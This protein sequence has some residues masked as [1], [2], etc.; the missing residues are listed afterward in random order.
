MLT[1]KRD[2]PLP[3]Q[4]TPSSDTL[5]T[6]FIDILQRPEQLGST[7]EIV[8][9]LLPQ[10]K[11]ARVL[12][13]VFMY[14]NT[15]SNLL[16]VQYA[17]SETYRE[18][19]VQLGISVATILKFF[20]L[21]RIHENDFAEMISQ[22]A[23]HPA[24]V[25]KE[26]AE[27]IRKSLATLLNNTLVP[28]HIERT[29]APNG[30]QNGWKV[31]RNFAQ[32]DVGSMIAMP[33]L[34]GKTAFARVDFAK[35]H[36]DLHLSGVGPEAL[37]E[38]FSVQPLFGTGNY[39]IQLKK[40]L[41]QTVVTTAGQQIEF[42]DEAEG[43]Q[44]FVTVASIGTGD[45]PFVLLEMPTFISIQN[46]VTRQK[47]N[48]PTN[49]PLPANISVHQKGNRATFGR[50][51]YQFPLGGRLSDFNKQVLPAETAESLTQKI[52]DQL[53]LDTFLAGIF[54][55][56]IQA[57]II[58]SMLRR[59]LFGTVLKMSSL[60][61]RLTMLLPLH[62]SVL[63]LRQ[64]MDQ[65]E[66]Q[67]LIHTE[68]VF[69]QLI[70]Q[71]H[72]KIDQVIK[73]LILPK[74]STPFLKE[75]VN[76]H[77]LDYDTYEIGKPAQFVEQQADTITQKIF[78]DLLS[79]SSISPQDEASSVTPVKSLKQQITEQ[80]ALDLDT[81]YQK[82]EGSRLPIAPATGTSQPSQQKEVTAPEM[83]LAARLER[84]RKLVYQLT[85]SPK[86]ITFFS[87]DANQRADLLDFFQRDGELDVQRLMLTTVNEMEYWLWSV[88]VRQLKQL[89]GIHSQL[90]S[91]SGQV[92]LE[93][94]EAWYSRQKT[95][96]VALQNA[97][98]KAK[99]L[100]DIEAQ[101][102]DAI[103]GLYMGYTW[104]EAVALGLIWLDARS[105]GNAK[106]FFRALFFNRMPTY[107]F[108]QITLARELSQTFNQL[109]KS[110]ISKRPVF[111]RSSVS[112]FTAGVGDY[113]L[114][115]ANHVLM[116]SIRVE[117]EQHVYY[118]YDPHIGEVHL[119]GVY[120]TKTAEA[121]K[122][123]LNDYLEEENDQAN[124]QTRAQRYGVEKING[125]YAFEIYQIN[126]LQAR[127]AWPVLNKLRT[128][129][130][131]FSDNL[132][133][134]AVS[135]PTHDVD[136]AAELLDQMKI[137]IE[138]NAISAAS[139][140]D[141][142]LTSG[143]HFD[144]ERLNYYLTHSSNS[145][146]TGQ[147]SAP[148]QPSVPGQATSGQKTAPQQNRTLGV[149]H[150]APTGNSVLVDRSASSRVAI[151]VGRLNTQAP[152]N[153]YRHINRFSHYGGSTMQG[154]GYARGIY[155]LTKYFEI[156]EN[157]ELS[158]PKRQEALFR[159]EMSAASLLSNLAI[160]GTQYGLNKLG[161]KLI[162]G[163]H[164]SKT[165]GSTAISSASKPSS[166][167]VGQ[168]IVRFGGPILSVIGSGF[169][170]YN[171]QESFSALSH[172]TG[173]K[174]RQDLIVS[175]SLSVIGA[176]VGIGTAIACALGGT[177]ATVAG[178][179]AL[180]AGL[181]LIISSQIYSSIRQIEELKKHVNLTFMQTL[182]SG[183][184][185]FWHRP[186]DVTIS[187]EA[188]Y[189]Q[190]LDQVR[191]QYNDQQE[192]YAMHFLNHGRNVS[193]LYY[194]RGQVT[195]QAH[196]YKRL[197]GQPA[198]H[199]TTRHV[200]PT[201]YY[202]DNQVIKDNIRPEESETV[203]AQYRRRRY[204]NQKEFINTYLQDSNYQFYTP[205]DLQSIDDTID[206]NAGS[207]NAV[208]AQFTGR[209]QQ[210]VA[211]LVVDKGESSLVLSSALNLESDDYHAL[212]GDFNGDGRLDIGYFAPQGFYLLTAG[213]NGAYRQAQLI[214]NM[215][216]RARD[217]AHPRPLVGDINSD[218][219][220]DI[221]IFSSNSSV[222]ATTTLNIMLAQE[223]GSFSSFRQTLPQDI[224]NDLTNPG[225]VCGDIDG[226]GHADL[227]SF[228]GG[229]IWIY[230][231]T[232]SGKFSIYNT[233][234][235]PKPLTPISTDIFSLTNLTPFNT[236]F[237]RSQ[238]HLYQRIHAQTVNSDPIPVIVPAIPLAFFSGHYV[239]QGVADINGDGCD[240]IVSFTEEGKIH[241]LLGSSNRQKKFTALNTQ[242]CERL[243]DMFNS[244]MGIK[245]SQ[246]QLDDID[247]DGR[248][249]LVIVNNDGSYT[250]A[251]GKA[252]GQ[253]GTMIDGHTRRERDEN[254]DDQ[255]NF[256]A[257]REQQHIMGITRGEAGQKVLLSLNT[258]GEV[259]AHSFV[260]VRKQ[261]RIVWF[262]LDEGDD[263][264]TG[265]WEQ[266]NY[267]EVGSG[268]KT[269]TGGRYADSFLLMGSPV[270]GQASLLDGGTDPTSPIPLSDHDIVMATA[271]PT[272]GRGY[273]I[274]LASN[275]V[276]YIAKNKTEG[277]IKETEMV[278]DENKRLAILR[279]IENAQGHSKTCDILIG[280]HR[281]NVLNGAGS[282]DV[283]IGNG[284]NDVLI[285][286]EGTAK[287]GTGTDSYRILQNHQEHSV[288]IS[289]QK[290]G[291]TEDIS[292]I[293]IDYQA[294][295]IESV[296]LRGEHIVIS[297]RNDN[298][299][300]TTL[301]LHHMY[302]TAANGK[303]KELQHDFL[304]YTR[305]GFLIKGWPSKVAKDPENSWQLITTLIAKY[306]PNLDRGWQNRTLGLKNKQIQLHQV[307]RNEQDQG[308]ITV[309]GKSRNSII[310]LPKFIQLFTADTPYHDRREGDDDK[311]QF[312]SE[313]GND[314]LMGKG[315]AD[316]YLI[317]GTN[318]Q[319]EVVIDN[320]DGSEENFKNVR[321]DS[322]SV[323][324]PV[325]YIRLAIEG[326]DVVLSHRDQPAQ[327]PKTRIRH[328]MKNERH[329]HL[330]L[331]SETHHVIELYVD[332]AN[333]V[334]LGRVNAT[335]GNDRVVI[336][337][338]TALSNNQLDV[339][340]GD[341]M[342]AD[343]SGRNHTLNGGEGNDILWVEEGDNIL[344]GGTGT[345]FLYGGLG[346]DIL[347]GGRD[348][349]T[350]EAGKGDDI[351]Q[352]A[353]G[354]GHDII[355]ESGGEDTLAFVSVSITKEK[356]WLEKQD[357]SLKVL[358]RGADNGTVTGS[359]LIKNY[360]SQPKYSVETIKAG[361]YQLSGE[362]IAQ[363]V[364]VMSTLSSVQGSMPSLQNHNLRAQINTLWATVPLLVH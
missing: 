222:M 105:S 29:F 71:L 253:F 316:L 311:N 303:Q 238:M 171:A 342:V 234:L 34:D 7:I 341:D 138:G 248:A 274:D 226:D 67:Q 165:V 157:E 153:K 325:K 245:T 216:F 218:G 166:L 246:I 62:P 37:S 5:K 131:N 192:Q 69:Q 167:K 250:F 279:N 28:L 39:R 210:Q 17:T 94:S 217:F 200:N 128:V 309:S 186:L 24:T 243:G 170:I 155:D 236:P 36:F 64:W 204:F 361:G 133:Q 90:S 185:L 272:D 286:S 169:D 339:L 257:I 26:A 196:P 158:D 183:W 118:L 42:K 358:I 317:K 49:I 330:S 348:N 91:L 72:D 229:K 97:G 130:D 139:L 202:I 335:A 208:R 269:F 18:Q 263:T 285:L 228:S 182:H 293:L 209:R 75:K 55:E 267:F 259:N 149:E 327:Y 283:L 15:P 58:P 114:K 137:T 195:L 119:R 79:G 194:S 254:G 2:T 1:A 291:N 50:A 277:E 56:K 189:Q 326:D 68:S 132:Q 219:R 223:D 134:S 318:P 86:K 271:E 281:N 136:L 127:E 121:L 25:K 350:L 276:G 180:A 205:N 323:P 144:L 349:D 98:M 10:S 320:Y 152:A 364:S 354:D 47:V 244:V 312:L 65:Q 176:A 125:Q 20:V 307:T 40:S 275:Y 199:T 282:R 227:V 160:D 8:T 147:P 343:Y 201:V 6:I 70:A 16:S 319:R 21:P 156:L 87:L 268:K 207:G 77:L 41:Q 63:S 278:I 44:F 141:I 304:L 356:I 345:D 333:Q 73:S 32:E 294:D 265:S 100:P 9:A 148:G 120:A 237:S 362:N 146:S 4:I 353:N 351:Y 289:L 151:A 83:T 359:V 164:S 322:L 310:L 211:R 305:D 123:L 255:P 232:S 81:F 360:Y 59:T 33:L 284:G 135:L 145:I 231:G 287:G 53:K 297:L 163:L 206:A 357:K 99:R 126:L 299:T 35:G 230:Y 104:T 61:K 74:V 298:H 346:N 102:S 108:S 45:N 270:S 321:R 301:E 225:P 295:K 173:K 143:M 38:D 84:T 352:F 22:I 46:S 106:R 92:A 212:M 89:G 19:R 235:S 329:R 337:N 168:K 262:K 184:L 300:L 11:L 76:E 273:L 129:F 214:E 203:H 124:N 175:G 239:H 107:S 290:T 221:I 54:A 336:Y 12:Q 116:L 363:M 187:N 213:E 240:D 266:R 347:S 355:T 85:F 78:T 258:A 252:D 80:L 306:E 48:L 249:D 177:A 154:Y 51:I 27:I 57:K 331:I 261:D 161:E 340:A 96:E 296:T 66:E 332:D 288:L 190:T 82:V 142:T 150:S 313:E 247:E 308:Q 256:L 264:A 220:D 174:E 241:T 117:N 251:Q 3:Q 242:S 188:S 109:K 103:H 31:N 159:L 172:T 315:G 338:G 344:D 95:G 178:P 324:F 93:K 181:I 111:T 43:I 302:A 193:T 14:Q 140:A 60:L 334:S 112:I 215:P 122:A 224:L 191:Q 30:Q 328:F 52:T 179:V 314:V 23:P 115:T 197:M 113:L 198:R 162:T 233:L 88:Q 101:T 280:N 292:N 260:A 13:D 110:G